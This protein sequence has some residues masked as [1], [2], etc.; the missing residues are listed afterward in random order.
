MARP[1]QKKDQ[2]LLTAEMKIIIF[3]I[4]I[5]TDLLLFGLFLW[6]LKGPYTIEHI[7]TFIFVGLGIDSLFY[8]FSV[9]S[10]RRNI[11]QYNPFSNPW[12]TGS[13]ALGFVLLVAAVYMPV[14]Q[15]FL[16]T[17]SLTLFDWELLL[18]LGILNVL[19]IEA[20]KW[21]FVHNKRL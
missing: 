21:Y 20:A 16:G 14:F 4:S 18:G 12:L 10:L 11:W 8:V 9:R 15:V 17:T 7:Q 6:L 13:V 3:A 19:L 1:P 5:F 2:A